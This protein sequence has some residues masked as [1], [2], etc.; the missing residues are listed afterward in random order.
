MHA[1][2]LDEPVT[3][4]RCSHQFSLGQLHLVVEQSNFAIDS[5]LS[6]CEAPL[7]VSAVRLI[8]LHK[9][10]LVQVAL[11]SILHIDLPELVGV[12]HVDGLQITSPLRG[13]ADGVR[14]V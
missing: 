4:L 7:I 12:G 2:D 13:Q 11:R 3:L 10:I 9:F 1:A 14:G 8:S 6:L 5:I